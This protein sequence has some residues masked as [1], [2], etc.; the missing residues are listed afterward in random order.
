[1][2]SKTAQISLTSAWQRIDGSQPVIAGKVISGF[3]QIEYCTSQPADSDLGI[4]FSA[5]EPFSI[6]IATG[7]QVWAKSSGGSASSARLGI[8]QRAA[9]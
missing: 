8:W 9:S 6:S 4:P 3:C 1:M 2:A 7:D 5:G